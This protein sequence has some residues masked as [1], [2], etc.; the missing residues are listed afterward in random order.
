DVPRHAVNDVVHFIR[1]PDARKIVA[2]PDRRMLQSLC[3]AVQRADGDEFRNPCI[4]HLREIG[5]RISDECG[6]QLPVRRSPRNLLHVDM[7][8]GAAVNSGSIRAATL[9]SWPRTQNFRW[10]WWVGRE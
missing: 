10:G 2:L 7:D 4:A 1:R 5:R 6:E 9:A 8:A 3:Q